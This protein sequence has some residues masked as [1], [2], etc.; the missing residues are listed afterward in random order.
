MQ[1]EEMDLRD[2]T[3]AF[4]LRIVRMFSA[5]PTTTEAQVLRKQLLRSE[6]QSAQT[7]GKRFG[8]GAKP[9]SSRNAA[10]RFGRLKKALTGWNCSSNPALSAWKSS[11]RCA[12]SVK[13]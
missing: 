7:I 9:S 8:R 6:L 13:S 12:R 4:A 5:L 2:R 1:K 11:Q 10:I 3:K